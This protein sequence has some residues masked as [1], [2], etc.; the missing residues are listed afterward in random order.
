MQ[1][2]TSVND[3]LANG[4]F[5]N[6]WR[7]VVSIQ[8]YT[9]KKKCEYATRFSVLLSNGQKKMFETFTQ[10]HVS[11]YV[12][13][14]AGDINNLSDPFDVFHRAHYESP[15]HGTYDHIYSSKLSTDFLLAMAATVD[16]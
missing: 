6:Y 8:L 16:L 5:Y 12:L 7:I 9:Y 3:W 4:I 14:C 1:I 10:F 13:P 15:R 2:R 11:L